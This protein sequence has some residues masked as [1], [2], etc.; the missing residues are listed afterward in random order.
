MGLC[1]CIL[2]RWRRAQ[3]DSMAANAAAL[4]HGHP[5]GWLP[6]AA[7]AHIVY[8]LT[9]G[10]C[11]YGDHPMGILQEC[12]ETL[13]HLYLD[14]PDMRAL[15][16]CMDKAAALSQN[17]A[18]DI[19]NIKA[20]VEGWV[21]EETL[22]IAIYCWLRYPTDFDKA[23]I[24]SVNHSGDSDSTG[25]V[26]GAILGATVG[27]DAISDKW[28]KDL[29][30]REVLLELSDDL[31]DGCQMGEMLDYI[32]KTWLKKY[33]TDSLEKGKNADI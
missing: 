27:Y 33:G 26:V 8:R 6:A 25:A 30:L 24:A 13:Y 21:A 31:C 3:T 17:E 28:K 32:D 10:D 7:F 9:F 12:K 29:E 4:T 1:V 16:S 19:A 23:I 14:S 11:K 2:S 22:A 18:A 20:L 15:F 5:L